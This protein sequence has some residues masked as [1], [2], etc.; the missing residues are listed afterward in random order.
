MIKTVVGS[1]DSAADAA[2]AAV[3]LRAAGF[4]DDDVNVVANN[5][6]RAAAD[7]TTG[8]DTATNVP[9]TT[10]PRRAAHAAIAGARSAV[11]RD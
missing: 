11:R 3:A 9:W 2:N 6:Q 4:M 7:A 5:A 8:L 1:F 10:M